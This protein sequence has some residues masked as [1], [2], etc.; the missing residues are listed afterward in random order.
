MIVR[1]MKMPSLAHLL[2][3]TPLFQW[4]RPSN[5]L[6]GPRQLEPRRLSAMTAPRMLFFIRSS[7]L[8][9]WRGSSGGAGPSRKVGR[10][11]LPVPCTGTSLAEDNKVLARRLPLGAMEVLSGRVQPRNGPGGRPA[12]P[13][14]G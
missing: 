5:A 2:S 10:R 14:E 12:D 4:C 7:R 9:V 1:T 8:G 13:H 3:V 6:F 11:R